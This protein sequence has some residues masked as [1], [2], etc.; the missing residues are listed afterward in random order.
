[1][2]MRAPDI[3]PSSTQ[4]LAV[5]EELKTLTGEGQFLF[6]SQSKLTVPMS[7][8]TMLSAIYR[9][10]YHLRATSHGFRATVLHDLE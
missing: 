3:V 8:N 1:M 5:P 4:A 9:M 2:K 7:E 6:P 10:D